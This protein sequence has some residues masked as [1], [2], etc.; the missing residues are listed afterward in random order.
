MNHPLSIAETVLL[1]AL[2]ELFPGVARAKEDGTASAS[3][4]AE[5][6]IVVGTIGFVGAEMRGAI[7]LVGTVPNW[8]SLAP[9]AM[10]V[11]AENE[12][13]LCDM[14]GE[15]AN[16]LA[17]RFRNAFLRLG[18]EIQV[19]TPVTTRGSSLAVHETDGA[20][21]RWHALSCDAG[22]FRLRLDLAVVAGFD[23]GGRELAVVDPNVQELVLF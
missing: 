15:I 8:R 2:R 13:M 3:A 16:M 5:R 22:D 14:V 18:V 12:P 20:A 10:R 21:V 17:G 19:A 6:D 9:L 4:S 11:A 23:F 7:T 1:A